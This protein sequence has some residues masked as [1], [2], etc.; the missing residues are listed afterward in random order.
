M[1][2]LDFLHHVPLDDQVDGQP[3]VVPGVTITAG[4]HKRKHDVV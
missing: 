3:L 4:N 1:P 2:L